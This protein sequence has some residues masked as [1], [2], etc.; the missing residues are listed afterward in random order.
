MISEAE[1]LNVLKVAH[2]R[3][4]PKKY[5]DLQGPFPSFC[6]RKNLVAR[7]IM[8]FLGF[9]PVD[10]L[11]YLVLYLVFNSLSNKS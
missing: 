4:K 2:G 11:E 1:D 8:S 9:L 6:S 3:S 10:V 7:G 5:D